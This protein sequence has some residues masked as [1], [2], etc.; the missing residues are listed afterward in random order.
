MDGRKG[1]ARQK[2]RAQEPPQKG[3]S[4]KDERDGG[5]RRDETRRADGRAG[6]EG[7]KD[8]GHEGRAI[9]LKNIPQTVAREREGEETL[10]AAAGNCR[11]AGIRDTEEG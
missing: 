8:E 4:E 3:G 6:Y 7:E 1:S 10:R 11:Q 2:G 9:F 5:G